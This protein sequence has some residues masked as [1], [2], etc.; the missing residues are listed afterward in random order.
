ML[1]MQYLSRLFKDFTSN[2]DSCE[3]LDEKLEVPSNDL[4]SLKC[5]NFRKSLSESFEQLLS[6]SSH[7]KVMDLLHH[8][9]VLVHTVH[10]VGG[11]GRRGLSYPDAVGS[12]WINV[13]ERYMCMCCVHAYVHME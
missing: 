8:V 6:A 3:G 2:S 1:R 7:S 5:L 10:C 12:L 13:A 4:A 11:E 9:S